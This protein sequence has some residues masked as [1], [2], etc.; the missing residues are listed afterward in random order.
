M[1]T[2][3]SLVATVAVALV[4]AIGAMAGRTANAAGP[5]AINLGS[6]ANFSVLA[7][8]AVT[9]T[10]PTTADRDVGVWAGSSVTGFTGPPNGTTTGTI[11]A[12]NS[13]AQTAQTD[14]TAAYGVAAN[15]PVT[16]NY[17]ALGGLTLV[18]GVYSSGG[19]TLDL[20]GTLTLDGQN[21][22]SSVWIFRAT[23]DLVTASSSRVS[24]V[25]GAS[26]CNVFWR[27]VSSATLG[28]GSTF[29]GTIMADQS[30]TVADGVTVYGRALAR[31]GLV[32]LINDR[33]LTLACAGG[34]SNAPIPPTRPPFTVA[35][36]ATVAPSTAP[37]ATATPTVAPSAP[38]AG[39]STP[40]VVPSAPTA[41]PGAVAAGIAGFQV[42]PSTSTG[43]PLS[44]LLL[45]GLALTGVGILMLRRQIHS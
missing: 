19:A 40:T 25:N 27:V 39:P 41:T 10:G 17:A 12:G 33:F 38:T 2:S 32:S 9:N 8:S 4:I 26:P 5:A 22:P 11:Q 1:K 14:L 45:L 15:D 24:F 37:V 36:S 42:L 34:A 30:V 20:T 21:D 31:I 23:S 35:P 18:G 16:A 28:S 29:A 44:P 3:K 13:T 43:D 7:G 6:A